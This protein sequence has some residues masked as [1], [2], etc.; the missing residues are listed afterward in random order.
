[1]C[2]LSS[3]TGNGSVCV[4]G[5]AL[6]G[7]VLSVVLAHFCAILSDIGTFNQK[8]LLSS[9]KS[10]SKSFLHFQSG[11]PSSVVAIAWSV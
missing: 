8:L 11:I 6:C 1:M 7:V 10:G 5:G 3:V 4:C 9:N 2:V